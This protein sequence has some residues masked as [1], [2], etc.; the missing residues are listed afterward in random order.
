[1][2]KPYISRKDSII[3]TA[4]EIIDELGIQ[5]LSIKEISTRE[6]VTDAALY[7]YFKSK[8]DIILGV[9]DYYSQFDSNIINTIANSQLR[10]KDGI[11]FF[12]KSFTEYYENYPSITALEYFYDIFRHEEYAIDKIEKILNLRSNY[13]THLIKEAQLQG[14]ISKDFESEDLS[15]TILGLF[16]TITLKWRMCKYQFSLKSRVLP[17]VDTLLNHC[18]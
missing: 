13:I 14:D 18:S 11:K 1:M 12:I 10:P 8:D 9:L 2:K 17:V 16:T 6:E 5:G 7:K 4:I 3:L 15:D